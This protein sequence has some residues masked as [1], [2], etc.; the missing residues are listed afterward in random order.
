MIEKKIHEGHSEKEAL[1]LPTRERL[2][3]MQRWNDLGRP[4]GFVPE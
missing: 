2:D 1:N 4:A 3:E